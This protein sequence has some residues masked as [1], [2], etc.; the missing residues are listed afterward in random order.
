[1]PDASLPAKIL[2]WYRRQTP[3]LIALYI[4]LGIMML[5]L[6]WL[7]LTEF[8]TKGEPREAVVSLSMLKTGDWI[9][10]VNNDAD[11]PYKPMMFHWIGA[12]TAWMAGGVTEWTARVPSAIALA[13]LL[14]ATF[15]FFYRTPSNRLSGKRS[16]E[17]RQDALPLLTVGML[18]TCFELHRAGANARVDMVL[19][20]FMVVAVYLLFRWW[21]KNREV[22]NGGNGLGK[23][24]RNILTAVPWAAILCMS[25]AML[26]KG[27]VGILLPCLICGIFMLVRG[28]SVLRA[29]LSMTLFALLALIIPAM[30]YW[31][32][33]LQGGERFL[34]LVLEENFGRMTGTMTYESHVNPWYYNFW[35]TL[36]GWLPWTLLALFGLFTIRR[37]GNGKERRKWK[38]GERIYALSRWLRNADSL[39]VYS[40]V[41]LCTIMLFFCIPSSKRSVYLMPAYPFIGWFAARWFMYLAGAS[42]VKSVNGVKGLQ[43]GCKAIRAYGSVIACVGI[44]LEVLLILISLFPVTVILIMG[45]KPKSY[46]MMDALSS[47]GWLC[48]LLCGIFFAVSVVWFVWRGKLRHGVRMLGWECVMLLS[49]FLLLDGG[50]Q[51]VVLNTKSLKAGA[52]EVENIAR[53][54]GESIYQFNSFGEGATANPYHLFE[55][56]FYLNDEMKNFLKRKPESGLL[57]MPVGDEAEWLPK[58][59][60]EGYEFE[61]VYTIEPA[62]RREHIRIYRFSQ[63]GKGREAG[64]RHPD[65]AI[66]EGEGVKAGEGL[67]E[68]KKGAHEFFLGK[69]LVE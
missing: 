9:L 16:S 68:E 46:A 52:A 21:R 5:L 51:P 60:Q 19:T 48:W 59:R 3:G 49:L 53:Q 4:F 2:S 36:V 47:P 44:L 27:P 40:L 66:R 50:L 20:A 30:W 28:E 64:G 58:F 45:E 6:P 69:K 35:I 15:L 55:L 17:G 37:H 10:P 41:S 13:M 24:G 42:R 56:D 14:A 65:M 23:S 11:I 43:G 63:L 25:C 12:V 31:E 33:W 38:I 34:E 32:A 29:I 7:G 67:K 8:N 1:M 57:A 26:T 61:P 22:H 62:G 54:T 39:T 18:F